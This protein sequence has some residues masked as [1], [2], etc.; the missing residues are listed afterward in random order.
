MAS[1]RSREP[2]K[3]I[4]SAARDCFAS[5][6]FVGRDVRLPPLLGKPFGGSA[7]LVD[8]EVEPGP[9]N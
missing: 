9:L 7:G 1:P 3:A 8:V 2:G 4:A 5:A 6:G